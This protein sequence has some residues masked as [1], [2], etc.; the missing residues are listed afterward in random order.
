MHAHRRFRIE[1]DVFSLLHD[2]TLALPDH[3]AP[4]KFHQ[5]RAHAGI[6][7]FG[8]GKHFTAIAAG[9]DASTQSGITAD[10]ATVGKPV[11]ITDFTLQGFKSQAAQAAGTPGW[12]GVLKNG[13]GLVQSA[14]ELP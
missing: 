12:C 11:L 2:P 7:V 8:D 1:H 5:G 10:L 4:G 3:H 9:T 6:A 13:R 14:L